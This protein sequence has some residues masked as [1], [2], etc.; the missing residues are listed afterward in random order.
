M[1]ARVVVTRSAGTKVAV[2]RAVVD[3]VTDGG[4]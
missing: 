3:R 1:I 2:T 4:N